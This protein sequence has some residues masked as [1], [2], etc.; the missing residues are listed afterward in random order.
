[1]SEKAKIIEALRRAKTIASDYVLP[2]RRGYKMYLEI[3]QIPAMCDAADIGF[4]AAANGITFE[5][6]ELIKEL[7]KSDG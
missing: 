2:D 6:D 4:R 3:M 5:I 1:M 7:E